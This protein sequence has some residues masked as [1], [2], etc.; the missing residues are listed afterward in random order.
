MSLKPHTIDPNLFGLQILHHLPHRLRLGARALQV[1]IIIIKLSLGIKLGSRLESQLDELV[2][3]QNLGKDGLPESAVL[4]KGLVH[5][6]P[7]VALA[8][9]VVHDVG[10]VR[11]DDVVQL[12]FGPVLLGFDPGCEL[13]VPDEGVASKQLLVVAGEGGDDVAFG[14]VEGT[15]G[16][17]GEEPLGCKLS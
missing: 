5:H 16:G 7:R 13:G 11:D 9:V 4:V 3:S 12:G 14:E 2:A 15:L 17:F 1:I 6:V 10:D 8:L